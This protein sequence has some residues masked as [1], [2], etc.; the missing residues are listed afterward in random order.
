MAN[1]D[2][3]YNR[4]DCYCSMANTFDVY[5]RGY[6]YCSMANT[7][8]DA[9]DLHD[10]VFDHSHW[11]PSDHDVWDHRIDILSTNHQRC[12]NKD[13]LGN[14]HNNCSVADSLYIHVCDNL[15]WWPSCDDFR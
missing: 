7:Y 15:I 8:D 3:V 5:N 1:K 9:Y 10:E 12:L 11:W 13:S 6:Y 2:E 4:G 14:R